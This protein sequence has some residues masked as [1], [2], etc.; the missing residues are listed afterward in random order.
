[1]EAKIYRGDWG[2]KQDEAQLDEVVLLEHTQKVLKFMRETFPDMKE[3]E[4]AAILQASMSFLTV[5]GSIKAVAISI[6]KTMMKG[7]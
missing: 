6:A 4:K 3:M 2:M 5:L 1:M 7:T